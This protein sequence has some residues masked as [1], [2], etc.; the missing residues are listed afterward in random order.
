MPAALR[1]MATVLAMATF[2]TPVAAAAAAAADAGGDAARGKAI[3]QTVCAACHGATGNPEAP[4]IPKLAGQFPEYLAKQL[5]A[6]VATPDAPPQRVNAVM[7]GIAA[8]LSA[9]QIE[10]VAAYYAGEPRQAGRPRDPARLARG[11]ALFMRGN[12][13]GDLPACASCHRS[14]G[15]G[16]QPDFPD[17]AGQDADYVE[18]QLA[19][20]MET[21]G[22]R[23]K[24]MSLIAPRIAPDERTALAD[25][26]ASLSVAK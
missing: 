25:Y 21:R 2:L 19:V 3:A 23:G 17:I 26:I 4:G 10:D 7:A 11:E 8:T 14:S 12:A 6:F 15:H 16:I 24:L 22:H 13:D 9:T 20:W 5:R 1:R 18:T